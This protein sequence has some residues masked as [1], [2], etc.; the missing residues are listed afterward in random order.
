MRGRVPSGGHLAG[1]R[2]AGLLS[3]VPLRSAPR[4]WGSALLA[5]HSCW[6]SRALE[7][8]V[9]PYRVGTAR[10]RPVAERLRADLVASAADLVPAEPRV[11]ARCADPPHAQ[12]AKPLGC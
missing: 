12:S 1:T 8:A 11:R 9:R 2:R 4:P 3:S 10:G 7:P 5:S 6:V